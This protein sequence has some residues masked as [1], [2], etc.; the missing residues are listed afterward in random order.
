MA[1]N[2]KIERE[3]KEFIKAMRKKFS[4]DNDRPAYTYLKEVPQDHITPIPSSAGRGD[5]DAEGIRGESARRATGRKE[6]N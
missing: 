4:E 3:Q 6:M 1:K 2:A 5:R